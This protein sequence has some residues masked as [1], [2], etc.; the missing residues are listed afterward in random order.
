[1]KILFND[2]IQNSDAAREL[3]SPALSDLFKIN[4]PIEINFDKLYQVNSIGI[5]N[6]DGTYFF[7]SLIGFI[8]IDGGGVRTINIDFIYDNLGADAKVF[9]LNI[10]AG[11]ADKNER[12]VY[13]TGNGLYIL[14][15]TYTVY[16]I[17]ITTDATYIGRLA[18]GIACNIPTAVAKEPSYVS[19]SE[20]RITLSGQVIAGAGGYNYRTI[21][22]DSRYKITN[23]IFKEIEAGY[24]YIGMGYPFFID[25]SDESYK[26]LFNKF[27]GNERNQRSMTFQSGVRKFL[28]SRRFE[29]EE[30]F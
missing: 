1:M 3:K 30:R 7:I 12:E 15:K 26:L 19:T 28:Y 5:G 10:D 25:L 16:K 27:Y 20:P 17:L 14:N 9:D 18:A 22:L 29:F 21:S 11:H 24:K 4:R 8:N 2:I 13:F 23:E 6:T